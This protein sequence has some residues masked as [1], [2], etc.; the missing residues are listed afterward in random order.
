MRSLS[1]L[2]DFDVY[3]FWHSSSLTDKDILLL[4]TLESLS[5]HI[6]PL[7]FENSWLRFRVNPAPDNFIPS[8]LLG[9]DGSDVCMPLSYFIRFDKI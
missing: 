3:A 6:V 9:F 2:I 7:G 5:T 1:A 8:C 4:Q